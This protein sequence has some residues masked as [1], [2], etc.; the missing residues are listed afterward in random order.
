MQGRKI[1]REEEYSKEVIKHFIHPK[2]MG[3]IKHA[4]AVG[5]VTNPVCKDTMK[6][7]LKIDK[8]KGEIKDAKFQTIGC[9]AAISS[10]D[11]ACEIIKGKKIEEAKKLTKQDI[12]K[13][14]GG[15]PKIKEHC[16]LL[17]EEAV[18]LAL[19]NYKRKNEK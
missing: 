10:S 5:Q 3:E 6:V 9:A 19:K 17:G 4:D 14:L 18:K 12:L 2:N 8:K 11:I 7:Y 1:K 13:K 15:L 16:S